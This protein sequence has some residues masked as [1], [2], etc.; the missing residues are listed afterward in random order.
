M[1]KTVLDVCCGG[2]MFWFNKQDTRALFV[3]NR[4]VPSVIPDDPFCISPDKECDFRYLPF[5]DDKWPLVVFDPPHM[6]HPG[7]MGVKYG[8]L[9]S[10]WKD[11]LRRGF[12]ECFRVLKPLGTLVFKWNESE[13]PLKD[14]L[15]LSPHPPLFGNRRSKTI[16]M[17]FQKPEMGA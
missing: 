5:G 14:V 17:V 9:S 11:D 12:E 4:T 8:K 3:D 7:V 6:R 10:T 1:E 2:K 15:A 16:W 13:I